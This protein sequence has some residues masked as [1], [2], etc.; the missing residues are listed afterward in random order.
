[1]AH[2]P[3]NGLVL[4]KPGLVHAF[5]FSLE[6]IK[7]IIG[8]ASEPYQTFYSI[9]AETGI[10]GGEICALRVSDLDLENAVPQVCQN[11]WG[12][13]IQTVK[14]Q[15]G[16]RRFPI[17]PQLVEHLRRHLRSSCRPNSL[18]L[19]FATGNGT[20]WDHSLIRKRKFHPLLKKLG[21]PQCG[22]HAFRHGN[23]RCS[24]RSARRWQSA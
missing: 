18:G 15:K 16:N 14:S 7:R 3:F 12:G 4:P 20:P 19:L 21:I 13:K 6:E 1:V 5:T 24:I 2:D 11:V 8:S 17:S 22:F 23:T 10:R 9:L